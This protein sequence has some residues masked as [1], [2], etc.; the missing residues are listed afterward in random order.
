MLGSEQPHRLPEL[1]AYQFDMAKYARKYRWPSWVIYDINYCREAVSRPALS[2]TEAAGPR[3]AKIFAQCFTAMAKD[4]TE[5]WCRTCQSL[6][7]S[8]LGFPMTP[9][10]KWPCREGE[11]LRSSGSTQICYNYNTK[12]CTFERCHRRHICLRCREHHPHFKC[13]LPDTHKS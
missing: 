7:H 5:A 4:P 13:P 6:D 10:Q 3:E 11:S 2:W 8:T 1:M 9:R 12:G